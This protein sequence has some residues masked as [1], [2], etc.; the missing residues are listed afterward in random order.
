[1]RSLGRRR[2]PP[3][4]MAPPGW[5]TFL[6]SLVARG[7]AGVKLV[8]SDAHPGLVDA[9]AATLTGCGL[10]ALPHPLHDATSSPVVPKSAQAFVATMVHTLMHSVLD[11]PDAAT[12]P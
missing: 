6:R 5:P 1:M 7:L 2:R 8:S 9:I 11:Q 10:A 3:P 4:R 12:G